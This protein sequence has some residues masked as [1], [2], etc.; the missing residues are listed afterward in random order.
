[1]RREG[2]RRPDWTRRLDSVLEALGRSEVSCSGSY[3]ICHRGCS[4]EDAL[5][6]RPEPG[7]GGVGG[8]RQEAV[9]GWQKRA[10]V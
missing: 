9:P 6:G 1:M 3:F 7:H 2:R 8:G 10:A 5:S 4:M